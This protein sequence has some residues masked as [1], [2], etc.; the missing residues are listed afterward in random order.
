[1]NGV[2]RSLAVAVALS[3]AATAAWLVTGRGEFWPRWVAFAAGVVLL[4]EA[5]LRRALRRPPGPRRWLAVDAAVCGLIATADL[6]VYVL[7]GGGYFWPAW[8]ILGL[9][10]I[11]ALHAWAATRENALATRVA[12]LTSSRRTAVDR[13]A[14]ELKRVE[15][16]LHDGAQA[17]L[18]SLALTLGLAKDLVGRDAGGAVQLVEEARQAAVAALDDLRTVMHSIHPAVLAD[19]G[20]GDAVRAL[21]LDLAVPATV[22]GDPPAGL[23]PATETAVY[24][25]VAEALANVVKHSG[26]THAEVAFTTTRTTLRVEIRDDGTG[27]ADPAAGS[28]L[29]GITDRLDAVDAR[30]TVSSPPGGPTLVTLTV[31]L[32]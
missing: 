30:L 23:S 16:D 32:S 21:A 13:Q 1:M 10:G 27:G 9:S 6:A 22:T 5:L 11:V 18:V 7:T 28:G 12:A 3:A 14:A 17:R 8:T 4:G 20:L 19:R 25:A 24:F 15:R 2:A 31:P 26:A 29:R